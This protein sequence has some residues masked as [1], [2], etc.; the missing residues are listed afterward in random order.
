VRFDLLRGDERF[1]KLLARMGLRNAWHE[2]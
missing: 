1:Q 2:R